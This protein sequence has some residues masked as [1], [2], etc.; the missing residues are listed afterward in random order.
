MAAFLQRTHGISSRDVGVFLG[1]IGGLFAAAGTF[2]GGYLA[3]R[4]SRRDL[5][6]NAWIIAVGKFGAAPLVLTFFLIDNFNIAILF[7]LPALVL[8]SFYL[9]PGFAIV[10]SVAPV[11]MRATVAAITLFILNLIAL[12]L[13]PVF[14]G[15]VSD[16]LLPTFGKDSL[17]YA[18][19]GTSVINIWAG[20][21]FLLAGPAYKREMMAKAA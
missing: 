13:G 21:H 14:V 4:L 8:A 12:G 9:G 1:P 20:V 19:M 17:R 6:W 3:D 7:Y 5:R 2:L 11:A 10:Q 18:L 16:A 15:A